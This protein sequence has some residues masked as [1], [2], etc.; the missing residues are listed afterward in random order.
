VEETEAA[1]KR[2]WRLRSALC[3]LISAVPDRRDKAIGFTLSLNVAPSQPLLQREVL[4]VTHTE[5][6]KPISEERLPLER[7]E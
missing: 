2:A 5:G 3:F 6:N 1:Q 4:F 7:V